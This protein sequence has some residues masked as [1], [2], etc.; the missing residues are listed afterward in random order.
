MASSNLTPTLSAAQCRA[1]R[2]LLDWPADELASRARV[3]GT[4]L[5]AFEQGTEPGGDNDPGETARLR[6]TLEAAGVE[7]LD[8]GLASAGGGPGLRVRA[9]A[10]Y[11]PA[12]QLN[13]ANDG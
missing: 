4:W 5:E 6:R 8:S 11:I 3:P 13:S 9:P 1:A 12:E 7:F 2:A 10:D